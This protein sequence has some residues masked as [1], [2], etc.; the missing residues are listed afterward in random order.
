MAI[1]WVAM[2]VAVF[3]FGWLATTEGNGRSRRA[4]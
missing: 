2:I 4:R 1:G 3:G